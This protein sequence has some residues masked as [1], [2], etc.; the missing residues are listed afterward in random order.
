MKNEVLHNAPQQKNQ[1][2]SYL[3]CGCQEEL[4]NFFNLEKK[5]PS[6]FKSASLLSCLLCSASDCLP[7]LPPPG[8]RLTLHQLGLRLSTTSFPK[9][10]ISADQRC[11]S[12]KARGLQG[13][14]GP[15]L[16]LSSYLWWWP[17][18]RSPSP[19]RPSRPQ[20][21]S[22]PDF[23]VCLSVSCTEK[24]HLMIGTPDYNKSLY[25]TKRPSLVSPSG[26]I[27]LTRCVFVCEVLLGYFY[28]NMDIVVS[29]AIATDASDSLP[30]QTNP[31][32]CLD[33]CRYLNTGKKA[34]I[35]L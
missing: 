5:P 8:Q 13:Q 15:S 27:K 2:Q 34:V 7:L 30:W 9:N 29:E 35:F 17:W 16:T 21:S 4:N 31:L 18:R 1:H 23:F 32:V 33:A 12:S 3:V 24:Q 25:P 10:P 6:C 20:H 11:T 28:F 22:L 26:G 19:P 14:V